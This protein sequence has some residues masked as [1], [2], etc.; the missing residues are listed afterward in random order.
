MDNFSF[1]WK[2]KQCHCYNSM[3][4]YEFVVFMIDYD[5]TATNQ[6]TQ[7]QNTTRHSVAVP[8]SSGQFTPY[9]QLT[10]SDMQQWI[11]TFLSADERDRLQRL[12]S[13]PIK[14]ITI[15]QVQGS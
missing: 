3:Y 5:L 15:K 2:P 4:G 10:A 6:T 13:E 9:D 14:D 11:H 1:V 7:A 12:A 8:F